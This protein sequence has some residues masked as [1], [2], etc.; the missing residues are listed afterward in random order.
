LYLPKA[1]P[2]AA[3]A[4]EAASAGSTAEPGVPPGDAVMRTLILRPAPRGGHGMRVY[5]TKTAALAALGFAP[6]DII[7]EIN[8]ISMD[9]ASPER[10]SL[11]IGQKLSEGETL[12]VVVERQGGRTFVTLDPARLAS[13]ETRNTL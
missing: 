2:A 11:N 7:H 9:E 6:G 3:V 1:T 12:S 5:G 4:A 8:G 10:N 13:I